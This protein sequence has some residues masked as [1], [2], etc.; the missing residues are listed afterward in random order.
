MLKEV[1][2]N[3]AV[4]ILVVLIG[5]FLA[6]VRQ[7]ILKQSEKVKANLTAEQYELAKK[8]TSTLVHAAE[9][10]FHDADG[11]KRLKESL[12]NLDQELQKNGIALTDD[13]KRQLVEAS[14][15]EM[16]QNKKRKINP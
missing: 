1:L 5:I 11:E 2:I 3:S 14:V 9:Q 12:T 13:Q 15:F 16:N 8:I 7:L 4:S 6:S 10:I